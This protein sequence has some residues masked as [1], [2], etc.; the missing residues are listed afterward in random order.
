MN[1]HHATVKRA[2]AQGVI[3]AMA[4]SD[5]T[6]HLTE[7]NI[8]VTFPVENKDNPNERAKD[9]L[10]AVIEMRDWMADPSHSNIRLDFGGGDFVAY[11]ANPDADSTADHDEIARDPDLQDLFVTLAEQPGETEKEAND[12]DDEPSGS[13]VPI[14]YKLL[15]AERG[16]PAHCGDWLA[17]TL[18][19]FCRVM[20]GKRGV[21]D[22]DRLEAIAG[23]NGVT[24]KLFAHTPGYQGRMRM[25]IRNQLTKLCAAK[26]FILIPDGV[27][28]GDQE[29]AAPADWRAAHTPK[30]KAKASA[31]TV[32]AKAA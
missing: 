11:R 29:I 15:Y 4:D 14:K 10:V 22:L 24:L 26:G 9:A 17:V 32:K 16:N 23:A 6:A 30:P 1:L 20:D 13:V 3:L 12:E 8:R 2:A 21:T 28:E 7:A 31:D 27:A 25:T 19:S 18:N 5:V